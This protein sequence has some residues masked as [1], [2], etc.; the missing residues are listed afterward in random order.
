MKLKTGKGT[1]HE[2]ERLKKNCSPHHR[3]GLST[4]V[5]LV[6]SLRII[7]SDPLR[8]CMLGPGISHLMVF[9]VFWQSSTEDGPGLR[10][11]NVNF[12]LVATLQEMRSLNRNV[13]V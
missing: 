11:S 8:T 1:T 12:F 4:C 9:T 7:S 10:N 6:C 3:S 5:L 13:L 2:H